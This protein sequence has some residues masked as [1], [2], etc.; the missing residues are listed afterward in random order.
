M[1]GNFLPLAIFFDISE[2]SR[3]Q[4]RKATVLDAAPNS[5]VPRPEMDTWHTTNA[6]LADLLSL[7][8]ERARNQVCLW[9]S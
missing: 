2:K 4:L 8:I 1:A 5:L 6:N 7:A 3:V 9:N